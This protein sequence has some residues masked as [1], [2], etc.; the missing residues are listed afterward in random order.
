M[1]GGGGGCMG[2]N[3]VVDASRIKFYRTGIKKL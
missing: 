3:V 1:G 2:T